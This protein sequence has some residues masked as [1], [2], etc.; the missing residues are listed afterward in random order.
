MFAPTD[1]NSFSIG[2]SD[3][4]IGTTISATIARKIVSRKGKLIHEKAK[5]A[6]APMKS[7]SSVAGML[8]KRLLK[9]L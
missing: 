1:W 3:I 7:G 8:M 4:W 2:T 6:S 9:K 5:A